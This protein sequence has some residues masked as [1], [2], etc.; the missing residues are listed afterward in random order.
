MENGP[1]EAQKR[2]NRNYHIYVHDL[3]QY[4]M[5]GDV[6]RDPNCIVILSSDMLVHWV[7]AIWAKDGG[8]GTRW[9]PA[10]IFSEK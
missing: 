8:S 4:Y 1:Q 3:L 10:I 6:F 2:P 9:G 5:G 7:K